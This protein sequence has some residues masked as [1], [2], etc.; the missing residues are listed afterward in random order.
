[1]RCGIVGGTFDPIHI[2]HLFI[3]EDVRKALKLDKIIFIPNG[4]PPHKSVKTDEAD[5]LY[6]VRL[7]TEDNENFELSDIEIFKKEN[8]YTVDTLSAL[9][10]AYPED[11]FFFI[12]GSDSL[13]SI[14]TWKNYEKIFDMSNIVCLKRPG[15]DFHE[16]EIAQSLMG[17]ILFLDS[18][19]LEISSTDIRKRIS[20]GRNIKYLVTDKVERYIIEKSLYR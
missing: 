2:G 13:L 19:M 14:H 16:L 17:Q 12:M 7:A 1:M 3:A 15:F 10:E 18:L 8:S 9:R 4:T 5:R 6:M 11:E 20:E